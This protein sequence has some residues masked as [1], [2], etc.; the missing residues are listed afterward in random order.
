[1]EEQGQVSAYLVV[2]LSLCWKWVY[3]SSFGRKCHKSF[4]YTTVCPPDPT[5]RPG[6]LDLSQS[7][8][9]STSPL[10][11]RRTERHPK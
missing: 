3:N 1:M 10:G 7:D 8:E 2:G 9:E 6:R 4:Q 5:P 11:T